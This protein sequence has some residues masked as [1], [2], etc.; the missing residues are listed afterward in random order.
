MNI[1]S[2]YEDLHFHHPIFK[3]TQTEFKGK[4]QENPVFDLLE[5]LRANTSIVII[6]TTEDNSG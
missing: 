5:G 1:C 4:Y 2:R 6:N 3:R